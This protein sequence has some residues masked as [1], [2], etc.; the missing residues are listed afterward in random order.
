[1]KVLFI[2][3]YGSMYGANK[4]LVNLMIDLQNRYQIQPVVL[5]PYSGDITKE[6]VE[7]NIPYLISK[8]YLWQFEKKS[9]NIVDNL[10]HYFKVK[11]LNRYYYISALR[12]VKK[13]GVS[14][15]HSNSSIDAIG[16]YLASHLNL[17]H[18]WHVREYGKL[19]YNTS[20]ALSKRS[21]QHKYKHASVVIAISES[22]KDY[23]KEY[24]C[25]DANI[26]VV[27]NGVKDTFDFRHNRSEER[28]NFCCVGL[29]RDTK[30]Q[31][32]ILRATCELVGRGFTD[33]VIHFIGDGEAQYID[34]MKEYARKYKLDNNVKFWGYQN[35]VLKILK[36]MDIGIMPSKN[37]AFGRVTVEYMM[38][39]IPVIGANTGGTTE[40]IIDNH[41]GLLYKS[42]DPQNLAQ[43]MAKYMEDKYLIEIHGSEAR[44]FAV[45]NFSMEV[46]T[47]NIY[48]Q[49]K[50][51]IR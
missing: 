31:M 38:E 18:I 41:T 1:M 13:L 42:G 27:Y 39:G 9:N 51:F 46:N 29:I 23:Y 43:Q 5:L 10:V 48:L 44:K 32:E 14:L 37:E 24:I 45:Q 35:D 11:T 21:V 15:V 25:P 34:E 40:L 19:D 30:N 33:F 50:N 20:Y 17:P 28:T 2:T 12:K 8:H 16:E 6:L 47:D 22:I 49:Y 3:N 26:I 36:K 4:S 7:N